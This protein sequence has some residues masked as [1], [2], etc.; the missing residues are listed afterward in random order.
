LRRNAQL[1]GLLAKPTPNVFLPFRNVIRSAAVAQHAGLSA[2]LARDLRPPLTLP[3]APQRITVLVKSRPPLP[4]GTHSSVLR[5]NA[6]LNGLLAKPTPNVFLPFRNV[7]RSAAVAQHAGLSAYLARDLRP[8]LTLPSAPK[9][10]TVL[11]NYLLPL[12]LPHTWNAWLNSART[13]STPATV[14]WFATV[15]S[16]NARSAARRTNL[17]TSTACLKSGYILPFW[18]ITSLA[19]ARRSASEA[20]HHTKNPINEEFWAKIFFFY[21]ILR[22][23]EKKYRVDIYYQK[24]ELLAS[25]ATL[26]SLNNLSENYL[27]RVSS[28]FSMIISYYSSLS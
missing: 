13:T 23:Y 8:P 17:V 24:S 15:S 4:S 11:V 19:A 3:S 18:M 25:S 2:Y 28:A 10:I 12:L 20:D 9:Q 7:I 22:T 6:Q 26:V 5:R 21:R 27:N 14:I 16:T 1:N